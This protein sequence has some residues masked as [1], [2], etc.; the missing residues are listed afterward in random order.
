MVEKLSLNSNSNL[1]K[2]IGGGG[3]GVTAPCVRHWFDDIGLTCWPHLNFRLLILSKE[4]CFKIQNPCHSQRYFLSLNLLKNVLD[5]C[6]N[7]SSLKF[8]NSTF[9][10]CPMSCNV[11]ILKNVWIFSQ[12]SP[13]VEENGQRSSPS[14]LTKFSLLCQLKKR[15]SRR[16]HSWC[17]VFWMVTMSVSSRMVRLDLGRPSQ[18]REISLKEIPGE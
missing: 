7:S 11:V 10:K 13:L 12:F 8:G 6:R 9:K 17:K 4:K 2:G 1:L 18:W 15:C 3:G 16:F 5:S 14:R